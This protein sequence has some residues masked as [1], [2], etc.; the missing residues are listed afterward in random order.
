LFLPGTGELLRGERATGLFLFSFAA[1]LVS[2]GWAIY[3]TLGR[4]D[5]TLPALGIPRE[6]G[7]WTLGGLYVGLALLHVISLAAGRAETHAEGSVHPVVAALASAVFPGLGQLLNGRRIKAAMFV[8]GLWV[9]AASWILTSPPARQL[10]E[11]YNLV[12][13]AALVGFSSPAVRWTLPAVLW[14]LAIYDA[15]VSAANSRN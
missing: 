1:F 5:L 7:I 8:A 12:L 6:A 11:S 4:L 9:V 15:A 14:T 10:L 13:P 3:E 2:L